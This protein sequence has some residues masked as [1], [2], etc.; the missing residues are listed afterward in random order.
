MAKKEEKKKVEKPKRQYTVEGKVFEATSVKD[1]IKQY[2]L[3]N[4]QNG[5]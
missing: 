4:K 3:L 2:N 5:K 1:A